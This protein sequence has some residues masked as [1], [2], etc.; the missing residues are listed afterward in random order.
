MAVGRV[1]VDATPAGHLE[2]A[3]STTDERRTVL[4][5]TPA[6]EALL[7]GARSWQRETFEEL[8]AHWP[9]PDRQ[10]FAAYLERLADEVGA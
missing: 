7:A 4:R 2:R 10:R 1:D 9:E 3:R 6:G 5:L 8:T